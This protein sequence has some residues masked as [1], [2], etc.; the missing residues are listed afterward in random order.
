MVPRFGGRFS[1]RMAS[2]TG[3]SVGELAAW[4]VRSQDRCRG[5]E[6]NGVGNSEEEQRTRAIP[7]NRR[8]GTQVMWMATFTC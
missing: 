1:Y 6:L 3:N 8:T 7:V 2:G 5:G 4:R